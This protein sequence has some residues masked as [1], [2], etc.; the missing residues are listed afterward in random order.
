MSRLSKEREDQSKGQKTYCL[1]C[2]HIH[3]G[4]NWAHICIGCPCPYQPPRELCTFE[5]WKLRGVAKVQAAER[6]EGT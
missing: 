2:G 3:Q 4:S 5:E 6:K 1:D